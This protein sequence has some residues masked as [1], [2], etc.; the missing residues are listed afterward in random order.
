MA[1]LDE[2]VKSIYT[3]HWITGLSKHSS[4]STNTK[5]KQWDATC[6]DSYR[7][8]RN[9]PLHGT[10]ASQ[11]TRDIASG[12]THHHP[13]HERRSNAT[14]KGQPEE[15][16]DHSPVLCLSCTGRKLWCSSHD[17]TGVG[18]STWLT[19]VP[20]TKSR[21]WLGSIDSLQSPSASGAEEMTP[22]TTA[23]ASK[24][25]EAENDIIN[26]QLLGR[27]PG[28]QTHGATAFD[29][30]QTSNEVVIAFT[31]QIG[32]CIGLLGETL[33]GSTL[34][35]PVENTDQSAGRY[36][37]RAVVVVVAEAQLPGDAWMTATGLPRPSG[38]DWTT[39]L[40]SRVGEPLMTRPPG[41]S[42]LQ[43]PSFVLIP[44]A[45]IDGAVR[46]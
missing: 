25:P 28:K 27:G 14:C 7:L 39:V 8:R 30:L 16:M 44:L 21:H 26:D 43:L 17:I 35:S 36:N 40:G 20:Q 41:Y 22:M 18:N 19:M 37:H 34:D 38:S 45:K 4:W 13:R 31:Q 12:G 29:N 42:L 9:Q 2:N 6:M 33:E 23:V 1:T 24:V 46:R 11:A 15:D 5:Q 10:K 3:L 32:E